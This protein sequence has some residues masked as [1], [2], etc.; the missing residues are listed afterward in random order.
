[1]LILWHF[2]PLLPGAE[3]DA[4][5]EKALQ[6]REAGARGRKSLVRERTDP[7]AA[8]GFMRGPREYPQFFS[9][10]LTYPLWSECLCP[11]EI[12]KIHKFSFYP[13]SDDLRG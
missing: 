5:L 7:Q 1:M 6:R 9:I 10:P 3:Y 12:H 2:W 4:I 8:G 11:V 13:Q